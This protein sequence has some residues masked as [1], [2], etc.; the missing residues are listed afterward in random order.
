MTI[1]AGLRALLTEV[2]REVIREELAKM[3][4]HEEYLPTAQAASYAKVAVGTIRRWVR[5]GRLAEHRAG[6]ELRVS[7]AELEQ[8]MQRGTRVRALD[9]ESPEDLAA[10]DFR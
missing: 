3:S 4:R 1:E 7:L 10:R 2:A 6:S 5:E 8:L 9:N